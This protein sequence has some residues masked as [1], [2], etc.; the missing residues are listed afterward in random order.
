MG[1]RRYRSEEMVDQAISPNQIASLFSLAPLFRGLYITW[2]YIFPFYKN[3][4]VKDV[5]PRYQKKI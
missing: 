5:E 2:N 1:R 3:N 4:F